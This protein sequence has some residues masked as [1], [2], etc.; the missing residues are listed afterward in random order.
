MS[1][2]SHIIKVKHRDK[3]HGTRV[4][5]AWPTKAG[6]GLNIVLDPGIAIVSGENIYVTAW[7]YEERQQGGGGQRGYGHSQRAEQGGGTPYDDVD[8]PIPF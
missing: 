6:G 8:E 7:P 5:A 1:K 4:G 3:S 2:P